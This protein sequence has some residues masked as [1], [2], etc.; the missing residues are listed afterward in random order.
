MA[1]ITGFRQKLKENREIL[2][3]LSQGRITRAEATRLAVGDVVS[4]F[5]R[6]ENISEVLSRTANILSSPMD[7]NDIG[8]RLRGEKEF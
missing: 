5:L 1:S 4:D 7:I 2:F 8:K 6:P 3:Q